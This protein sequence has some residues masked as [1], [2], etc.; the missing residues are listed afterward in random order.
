MV[1]LQQFVISES[2]E[3]HY[4]SRVAMQQ[5]TTPVETSKLV[6]T[7]YFMMSPFLINSQILFKYT[8]LVFFQLQLLKIWCTFI[9]MLLQEENG[10]L[11]H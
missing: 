9:I 10:C 1:K 3:V 6:V 7:A 11:F 8:E 4:S 2:D 5:L